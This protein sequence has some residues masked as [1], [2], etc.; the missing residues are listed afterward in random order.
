[1][2]YKFGYLALDTLHLNKG[3]NI[4]SP[5]QKNDFNKF[6]AFTI[7]CLKNP[8]N[9]ILGITKELTLPLTCIYSAIFSI[10]ICIITS[11]SL[12]GFAS[13]YYIS[14]LTSFSHIFN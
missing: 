9:N 2:H 8:T 14:S 13:D 7:D 3:S 4:P 5:I 12:R 10:L 1:M 6:G 11:I